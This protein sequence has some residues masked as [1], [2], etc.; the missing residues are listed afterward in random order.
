M[1]VNNSAAF[2]AAWKQYYRT[3]DE[4]R[5][6]IYALDW[7]D[8]PSARDAVHYYL[9]EVQATAFNVAIGPRRDY[10]LLSLQLTYAPV[11]Y[12]LSNHS[13][14]FNLR[15][16]LVDGSRTYRLWGKRKGS[17]F[18][19]IQM[20][21]VLWGTSGAR[22]LGNYDVD[23]FIDADG[24]FEFILSAD[25]QPGNWIKLDRD[26]PDNL[27]LLREAFDDWE[28]PRT[29]INIQRIED[30]RPGRISMSEDEI[31]RRLK[32]ASD[33]IKF[34]AWD[35]SAELTNRML[36]EVGPNRF[37]P[38]IFAN[39]QGAGNNPQAA[40]P[41]AVYELGDA[42]AIVVE[43]DIPP[44]RYWNVQLSTPMWQVLDFTYFH[45]SLNNHQA[46][47][48]DDGR[49]RAIISKKD[50]GILNWLDPVDNPF[51]TVFFRIYGADRNVE[52]EISFVGS[53]ADALER[54]PAGTRKV[55]SGQR[56]EIMKRRTAAARARFQE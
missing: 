2:E 44:A 20:I 34:Y 13:A 37:H 7:M 50:P 19:D 28:K 35:W 31:I 30:G 17:L 4:L 14:D 46:H 42:E 54:L 16:G 53:L 12:T 9:L 33:Y 6:K 3:I 48:D 11:I 24:N 32:L 47:I 56:G 5:E 22:K 39:D 8:K 49:F 36:A 27:I 40:Y 18:V 15:F 51:G 45:V 29:E 52:P 26:S 41:G 38:G 43:A 23:K 25:P 10:P 1:A 55:T 21:N